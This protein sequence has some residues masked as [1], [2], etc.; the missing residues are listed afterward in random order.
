[1]TRKVVLYEL[2]SLDGFADDPGEGEWFG[3]ADEKLGTFLSDTITTQD[4]VLLGR[5]TYE[6]WAPHWPTSTMQPFAD[7]INTVPKHVFSTSPLSLG[8]ANAI[9]VTEP[10]VPYVESLTHG[11]GRDIGV[12]GSLSLGRALLTAGLVDEMRL[13]VAASLAGGGKP[14]LDGDAGLQ[15]FSLV[16]VDKSGSCL[17]LHYR[18]R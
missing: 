9:Q 10:L 14:L 5:R 18:R 3:D 6:K 16:N 12:H 11:S 17:L 2:M 15:H 1:M 4:T 13:V 7:F 8:W